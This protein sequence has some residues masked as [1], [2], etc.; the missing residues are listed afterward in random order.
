MSFLFCQSTSWED[1]FYKILHTVRALLWITARKV[2]TCSAFSRRSWWNLAPLPLPCNQCHLEQNL[3]TFITFTPSPPHLS[4]NQCHLHQH[5]FTFI[6]HKIHHFP[7][8]ECWVH[9]SDV[10]DVRCQLR[11]QPLS[12][13]N[14]TE[15]FVHFLLF[16]FQWIYTLYFFLEIIHILILCLKQRPPIFKSVVI[17]WKL[18]FLI[19]EWLKI[20]FAHLDFVVLSSSLPNPNSNTFSPIC[21]QKINKYDPILCDDLERLGDCLLFCDLLIY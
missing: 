4:C 14:R 12:C 10:P 13:Q 21:V 17:F 7:H 18:R 16:R 1:F 8:L 11:C 5:L 15:V 2:T 19:F 6:F 20:T 9:P 3:S